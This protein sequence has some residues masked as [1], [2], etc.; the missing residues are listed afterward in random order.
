[1]IGYIKSGPDDLCN[2]NV[3]LCKR[4]IKLALSVKLDT[5]STSH[6]L[7]SSL[8]VRSQWSGVV[9]LAASGQPQTVFLILMSSQ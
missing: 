4:I 5:S 8:Y 3:C 7:R 6:R 2:N 1:M 9:V